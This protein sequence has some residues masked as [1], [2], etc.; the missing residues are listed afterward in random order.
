MCLPQDVKGKEIS[1]EHTKYGYDVI[2]IMGFRQKIH[3]DT[4]H[5]HTEI[6][7]YIVT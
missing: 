1:T 2:G 3:A 6:D 5:I 7:G 4:A